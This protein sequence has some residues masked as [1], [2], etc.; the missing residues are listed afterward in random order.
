MRDVVAIV[1]AR[2]DRA[3]IENYAGHVEPQQGH[4]GAGD[5]LIAGNQRDD[6]VK[7]V[8]AD[9]E[10]DR[11]RD[12][13]AADQRGL[14][15]LGAHGDAIGDGDGIEFHGG[16]AGG[17]DALLHLYRQL[18]EVVIARHGLDPCVGDADDRLD[19]VGIREP[20]GFQHGASGSAVA[21]LCDGVAV[22]FHG[23]IYS[24][25]LTRAAAPA[26]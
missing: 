13:F 7:H 14:H 6:A 5:G 17:A 18:A 25:P 11:V 9:Q 20:D 16:A 15:A 10:L 26:R 2:Q 1:F 24:V 8:A 21:S 22:E 3:A 23:G 19:Q 4:C 12:H